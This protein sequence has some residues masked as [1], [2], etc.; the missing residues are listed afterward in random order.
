MPV[1]SGSWKQSVS[2]GSG[3]PVVSLASAPSELELELEESTPVAEVP[4]LHT[5]PCVV[6]DEVLSD[7]VEDPCVD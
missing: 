5:G 6:T 3:V 2:S 1:D 7:D 4:V